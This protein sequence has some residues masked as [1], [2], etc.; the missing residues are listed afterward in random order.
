M[1]ISENKNLVSRFLSYFEQASVEGLLD[2]MSSE[3]TWWVNGKP[4]LFAFAGLKSKAE[5]RPVFHELFAFFEDG[6]KM[7][8]KSM[9]GEGDIV[10]V[11]ARSN[12]VTKHEERYENEYHMSF[13]LRDGQIVEVR[14]YTDPMHAVEVLRKDQRCTEIDGRDQ[15]RAD[16]ETRY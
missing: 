6:L 4:H 11:E 8:L 15:P 14:E 7:E 2:L 10:A 13:R 5:M 9:I 12:G 3:A 16:V 1:N